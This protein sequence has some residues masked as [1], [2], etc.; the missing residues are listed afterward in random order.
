M[1]SNGLPY[2]VSSSC[3][4][5]LIKLRTQTPDHAEGDIA[6]WSLYADD[7]NQLLW[8]G[9]VLLLLTLDVK[10]LVTSNSHVDSSALVKWYI[11]ILRYVCPATLVCFASS[12][13]SAILLYKKCLEAYSAIIVVPVPPFTAMIT[14][15]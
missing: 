2:T 13:H 7:T 15:I 12:L 5:C 10:L 9:V 4:S 1:A 6:N 11:A 14:A 8:A 3:I